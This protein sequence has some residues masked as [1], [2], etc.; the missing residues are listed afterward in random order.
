MGA[1]VALETAGRGIAVRGVQWPVIDGVRRSVALVALDCRLG[2]ERRYYTQ[3]NKRQKADVVEL[4]LA[5]CH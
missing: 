5:N 1:V 3:D 2:G 4:L